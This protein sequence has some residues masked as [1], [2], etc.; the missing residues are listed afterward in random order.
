V[1]NKLLRPALRLIQPHNQWLPG[2]K[3]SERKAVPQLHIRRVELVPDS[4]VIALDVWRIYSWFWY[5]TYC[6]SVRCI[7]SYVCCKSFFATNLRQLVTIYDLKCVL[8]VDVY[9]F[10]VLQCI[11]RHSSP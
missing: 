4:C 6:I 8:L 3:R 7:F 9:G 5:H 1:F 2:T 11:L 10:H